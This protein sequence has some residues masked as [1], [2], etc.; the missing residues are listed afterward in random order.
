MDA[1]ALPAIPDLDTDATL[2]CT[3]NRKE[4]A[5]MGGPDTDDLSEVTDEIEDLAADIGH[6]VLAKGK[7]DVI[8]DGE[9]TRVVRTGNT[10]MTVG[11]TGDLLAGMVAGLFGTTE[12][13]DAA[14]V[15]SFVNGRAGDLCYENDA[16]RG[17]YEGLLASDMLDA[18]PTAMWGED[19]A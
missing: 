15:G 1:D 12:A 18:I 10:G 13:F 11:G 9:R 2:I 8:S 3:P 14:C 19:D 6:V 7:I 4:L 5:E 17:R 16:D